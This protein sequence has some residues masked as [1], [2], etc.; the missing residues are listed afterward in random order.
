[1]SADLKRIAVLASGEGT[2]FQALLDGVHGQDGLEVVA[3][4]ASK[5]GIP[6]LDRAAKAAVESVVFARPDFEGDREARDRAMAEWLLDRNVGLIVTAGWMELLT[7]TFL[8]SFKD[9]VV[10]VHPSLLPDFPGMDAVGQAVAARA[11]RIGV[12]VHLVDEGVDTGAVLLQ[13]GVPLPVGT[14]AEQAAQL[15]RPIE[16]RLLPEAVRQLASGRLP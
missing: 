13:E 1:M 6:A 3:L 11:E 8:D 5:P 9:Q 10:N 14:T 12:T 15:T 7:S 4:V 16:H 2:N